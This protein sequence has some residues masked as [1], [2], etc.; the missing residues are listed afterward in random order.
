VAKK[1]SVV[2]SILPNDAATKD[3]S[4]RLLD[5]VSSTLCHISCSTVSPTTSRT[6][7]ETYKAS[8]AQFISAPVFAR[9]D[10][11]F[12][13]QAT[14]M[15]SGD[16]K[17]RQIA[18]ELLSNL[19]KTVDYGDDV[20]AGNVVKLCGNFLIASSIE[21]IAESM[22]LAEKHGV[23][24]VEVMKLLSSSIFDCL[25]YKVFIYGIY[26]YTHVSVVSTCDDISEYTGVRTES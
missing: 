22:V 2:L 1:C 14:W 18:H 7:A 11:L 12:K 25:I 16:S 6:L 21:S 17:G 8:H 3:V 24:R 13:R 23:D 4:Q 9:P 20:G 5:N 19:G 15:V 26:K 10:G